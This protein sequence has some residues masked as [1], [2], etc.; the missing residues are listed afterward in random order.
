MNYQPYPYRE[1]GEY[2][3]AVGGQGERIIPLLT[4]F[5]LGAPFWGNV[6]RPY[7][8]YQPYPYSYPYSYQYPYRYPYSNPYYRPYRRRRRWY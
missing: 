5:A 2:D 3:L 1:T 4:G 8:N 6:N 7:Y